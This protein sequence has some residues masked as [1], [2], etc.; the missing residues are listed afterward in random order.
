VTPA[1][2]EEAARRR[3]N[4]VDS[5][6]WSQDELFKVIWEGEQELAMDSLVIEARDT[7]IPT[8]AGTRAY[9]RPSLFIAIKRIEYDGRKL[10]RIDDREDDL[11]TLSDAGT[12]E[13]GTP[14]YY[15]EWNDSIY[16]RPIPDAVE[17]LTIYGFKEATLLTTASTTL[18]T[19]TRCHQALIKYVAAQMAAKDQKWE[20]YDRFMD[21]W[22][23]DVKAIRHWTQKKKRTDG[24]AVV[25]DEDQQGV[26]LLGSI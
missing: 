10:K 2:V 17:T 14:L 12:A 3:Y 6:F 1:Q 15:W 18:S 19:P 5:G 20:I 23:G 8:V 26:T 24:F 13:Q 16:L 4:A 21:A 9:A 11:L 7:S 25:K 22:M